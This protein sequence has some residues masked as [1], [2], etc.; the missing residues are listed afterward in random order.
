MPRIREDRPGAFVTE[1][2]PPRAILRSDPYLLFVDELNSAVPDVQKA[3][4]SLILDRRLGDLVVARALTRR[5]AILRRSSEKELYFQANIGR[6]RH[7]RR[8]EHGQAIAH[9]RHA[10]EV[11]VDLATGD[12]GVVGQPGQVGQAPGSRLV[13]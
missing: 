4:Y 6:H 11:A 12:T 8:E 10:R 5:G 13:Y 1:F 9:G 7:T 3:F 2:C